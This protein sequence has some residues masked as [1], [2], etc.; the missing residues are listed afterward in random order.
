[1]IQD[2]NSAAEINRLIGYINIYDSLIHRF[3]STYL[4]KD[5]PVDFI[6]DNCFIF[7]PDEYPPKIRFQLWDF[8]KEFIQK[9][10]AAYKNETSLLSDKSRQMGISWLA[11]AFFLWGVMYDPNFSGLIIS[12]Q[13]KLVDDGGRES[14][15]NSLLGKLQYMYLNLRDILQGDLAFKYLSVRN[16]YSDAYIVG[17]S[18]NP[19]AGRSGSYRIGL[20][21]ECSSS[22]KSEQVFSSFYQATRCRL[23]NS[24]PKGHGN[25]FARLRFDSQSSVE[26]ITMHWRLHPKKG[27]EATQLANGQWVSPWY[28][29]EIRDMTKTQVAQELDIDYETSVE[30]RIYDKFSRT[31]HVP[32]KRI[33]FDPEYAIQSIIAWD[34]GIADEMVGIVMQQDVKGNVL[35]T[36]EI[37]GTDEEVRFYIQLICGIIPPEF[38]Y[39]Y[40]E[41]KKAYERFRQ[42]ALNYNYNN[43]IQVAGP[44]ASNRTINS[45]YSVK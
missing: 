39:S 9:L 22:V 28:S 14:T 42:N 27:L 31:T 33:E 38:E 18:S 43:L 2:S 25:L 23:Y 40:G 11:T 4:Y 26:V 12:Y 6:N 16:L 41:K 29:N 32:E 20:W 36:D 35:I 1:M 34:L 30:G 45:K 15:I 37:I 17:E 44:D 10:H 7:N 13:E 3:E 8:Q 19:N 5:N 24:T 21:D